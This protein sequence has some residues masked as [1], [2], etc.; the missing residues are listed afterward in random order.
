MTY[1]LGMLLED[2]L[3]FAA[4]SRTNA[5]VDHVAT[6]RKLSVFERPGERVMILLSAGSLATSQSVISLVGERLGARKGEDSLF[7]SRTMFNAARIVGRALREVN[8]ADAEYVRAQGAD[9]GASFILGGQ[10]KGRAP[11]LFQIYGAGNFIEATPE[12]PYL[13]IGETKYG[14]PIIDRTIT[15]QSSLDE[16]VKCALVSFDATMRSNVSVGPPIDIVTYRRDSL[17]I[18]LRVQLGEDDP[19]LRLIRDYWGGA[20]RRAFDDMPDPDWLKRP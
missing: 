3:V 2:G 5:G 12:T 8:D 14:K 9:P 18:G 17:K 10:I 19:F 1:C 7:K 6:F 11:R 13:Q 4:D 20:L 15:F 16:A